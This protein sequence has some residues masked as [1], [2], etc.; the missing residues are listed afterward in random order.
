[1]KDV[2]SGLSLLMNGQILKE[3][4]WIVNLFRHSVLKSELFFSH[5][6][7]LVVQTFQQYQT[8]AQV[9]PQVG[10]ESDPIY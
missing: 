1:M 9:S 8:L 6:L 3:E 10:Q 5:T 2:D 7:Q 4:R